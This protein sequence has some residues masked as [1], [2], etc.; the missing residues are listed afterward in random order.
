MPERTVSVRVIS[1]PEPAPVAVRVKVTAADDAVR[2]ISV[3]VLDAEG[4]DDG[5]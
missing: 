2:T 4:G 5:E 1:Q 3:P